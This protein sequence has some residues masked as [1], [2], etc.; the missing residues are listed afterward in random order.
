LTPTTRFVHADGF[1]STRWLTDAAG[2]V[3]DSVE[4]DAFGNTIARSGTTDVEHLYRSEQFDPNLGFYYLRARYYDPAMG[5]FATMDTYQGVAIDPPSLHRYFAL[6]ADPVNN[7]D[8]SG[9][10]TMQQMTQAIN[11]NP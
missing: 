2:T 6:H 4:Y 1:G 8:P 9:L 10:F 3:T 7:V 11:L 5:R